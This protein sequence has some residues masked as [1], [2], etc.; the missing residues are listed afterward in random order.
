MV[1]GLACLFFAVNVY[2]KDILSYQHKKGWEEYRAKSYILLPKI[3]PT[4]MLNI[5][6]YAAIAIALW[7]FFSQETPNTFADFGFFK[8]AIAQ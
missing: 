6:L 2:L 5:A 3:L 4:L 1:H 7:G 8:P